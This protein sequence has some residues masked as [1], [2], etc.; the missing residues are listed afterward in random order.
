MKVVSRLLT[1]KVTVAS[2]ERVFHYVNEA[3]AGLLEPGGHTFWGPA[4][5]HTFTAVSLAEPFMVAPDRELL[6]KDPRL[7]GK[8]EVHQINETERGLV[9]KGGR[10]YDILKPSVQVHLKSP[11]RF[12]I[13][14]VDIAK[15]F[16][17]APALRA[18]LQ[19][20]AS[21]A[22]HVRTF[23][24]SNGSVGLQYVDKVLQDRVL[25]P[26]LYS[27]WIGPIDV[28]VDAIDLREQTYEV[29]GQELMT[30]DKVSI[31]LNLSVRYQVTDPKRVASS[32]ANYATALHRDLQLAL[33]QEIAA[34]TLEQL[35]EKKDALGPSIVAL[36]VPQTD[37]YGVQLLAAGVRDIILPGEMRTIFNQVIEAEKRAQ[38]NLIARREETAATRNLLN[39]AKLLENNPMLLRLK[40]LEMTERIAEKIEHVSVYGGVD[41]VLDLLK[42]GEKKANA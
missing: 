9:A 8:L 28:R 16:E 5:R 32:Q 33:R 27:Y 38:A 41:A 31:R 29:S 11:I 36:V 13:E 35:L 24:V 39:T 3:F 15:N 40:E 21:Y 2:S 19:A 20:V 23:E 4:G 25:P 7:E 6:A 30:H 14:I 12:E 17:I 18:R 42:P 34:L 22:Q 10:L 26:G 1:T 37:A